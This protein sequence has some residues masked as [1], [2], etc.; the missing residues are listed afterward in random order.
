[1]L[2]SGD[3]DGFTRSQPD[4]QPR[5]ERGRERRAGV[6]MKK[7]QELVLYRA[8][9]TFYGEETNRVPRQGLK[10]RPVFLKIGGIEPV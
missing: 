8:L 7:K 10:K 4:A 1:L 6:L 5:R 2:V 9:A 3:V